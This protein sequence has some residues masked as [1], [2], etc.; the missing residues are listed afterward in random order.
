MQPV[1]KLVGELERNGATNGF[2]H[3]MRFIDL[4]GD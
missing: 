1:G 4:E 3:Y 2:P